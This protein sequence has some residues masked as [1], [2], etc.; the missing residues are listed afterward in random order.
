MEN[1][2]IGHHISEKFN[3]E[4][5][6]IRNKVLT[7]GGLVEQ[8]IEMAVQAF[9]SGDIELAELVIKQDNQVDAL[10]MAID[11]EC[12]QIMALRQPTAFD[13]RMLIAVIKIVREMERAG[14][15]AERIA[16][17][18]IQLS[19]ADNQNHQYELEHMASL[20]MEMMHGALDAFA[21][22]NIEDITMITGK[23]ENVNREYE[24]II[25]RLITRMMEDPRNI[26]RALDVIWAAR[27]MERIGDYACNIC[28]HL[29][30]MVN[31]EDVRHLTQQELEKKMKA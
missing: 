14:D 2:E 26:T 29:I 24:N 16:Q 3:Q 30:Y 9:T 28:E 10:E 1:K 12:T 13:L 4:L 7:M 11:L 31:G 27:A 8:Q 17:M 22:V 20:I 5:E 18:A 21:R 25:R 15:K 23:D 19:G 6:D